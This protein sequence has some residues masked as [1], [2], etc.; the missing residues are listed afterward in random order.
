MSIRFSR[1]AQRQMKW[2]KIAETEA[3]ATIAEPD[4]LRDTIKE[5]KNAFKT[6]GGRLVKV[7]YCR[8]GEDIVVVTAVIKGE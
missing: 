8:E 6:L 1:H 5:R 7:T 2:R 3:E 4:M